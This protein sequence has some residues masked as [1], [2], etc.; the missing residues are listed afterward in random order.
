MPLGIEE[1]RESAGFIQLPI[2]P[3]VL[4]IL[5]ILEPLLSSAAENSAH[6]TI[7]PALRYIMRKFL[8]LLQYTFVGIAARSWCEV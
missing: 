1:I 2:E 4:C 8:Y 7:P 3:V 5:S 6:L